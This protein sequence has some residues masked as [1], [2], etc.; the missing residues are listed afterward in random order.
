[1][2][3]VHNLKEDY[4]MNTNNPSTGMISYVLSRPKHY[5]FYTVWGG[6]TFPDS[7][8]DST[9]FRNFYTLIYVC[10]GGAVV[11]QQDKKISVSQGDFLLLAPGYSYTFCADKKHPWK[12]IWCAVS[13]TIFMSGLL[14]AYNIENITIFKGLNSA[15]QLENIIEVLKE[16]KSDEES[17]RT[18]EK[19]LFETVCQLSDFASCHAPSMSV[20]EIGKAYID[21]NGIT[22]SINDICKQLSVS[23]S[24]FFRLFTKEFG[25]S[26]QNYIM[27]KKLDI[28]KD[29]LKYTNLSVGQIA[30]LLGYENISSF[31]S[32]FCRKVGMTPLEY[33]KNTKQIHSDH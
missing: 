1:M 3:I 10:E 15:L 21:T 13:N 24:Y 18:V 33:R 14:S 6:V 7:A 25:I 9:E 26:P 30:E 31:S 32:L 22:S 27:T 29:S 12:Q 5:P 20:A 8:S 2:Q 23:T 28:A 19:L 4:F 17:F 16:Q 11:Y